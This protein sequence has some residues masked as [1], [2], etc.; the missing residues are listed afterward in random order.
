MIYILKKI[1]EKKFPLSYKFIQSIYHQ[2]PARVEFWDKK[3]YKVKKKIE[4]FFRPWKK[5]DQLKKETNVVF[6]NYIGGDFIDVGA[7]HGLYS[8]LLAPKAKQFDHFISCEPDLKTHKDLLENLS[9]LN[10]VFKKIKF[11]LI[12]TPINTGKE[13]YIIRSDYAHP[14]FIETDIN[15]NN[16]N[17]K[18][19]SASIDNLVKALGLNPKFIKID[20]EGAEFEVLQGM[21]ETM[22]NYKPLIYLEKHP[23]LIPANITVKKID[24]YLKKNNYKIFKNIHA[25]EVNIKEM[26]IYDN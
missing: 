17:K 1:L 9:I 25:D 6:Q 22:K 3:K 19:K 16:S 24:N 26:W 12:T 8:F 18:T 15:V 5:I 11:S 7:F 21:T 14:T 10:N 2:F 20:V 13:T 4:T 23:Q